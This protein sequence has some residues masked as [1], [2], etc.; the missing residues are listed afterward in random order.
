M[1]DTKQMRDCA[2]VGRQELIER[3]Q[4][5]CD[6]LESLRV[7]SALSLPGWFCPKLECGVFNGE[8]RERVPFCRACGTAC[9]PSL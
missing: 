9:P 5:L 6:E 1:V 4:A 2:R 8:A 3:I 7:R